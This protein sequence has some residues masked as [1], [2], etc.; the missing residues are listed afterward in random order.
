MKKEF[1]LSLSA[2][3]ALAVLTNSVEAKM[4]TQSNKLYNSAI[5]HEQEGNYLKALE[6]V[7]KSLQYSPDDAV[8]NIKLAGLYAN[9]GKYQEAI[10]A[11]NK[12]IL[13]RNDD[14]FLHI[15]L[16]NLYLQQYD[17]ALPKIEVLIG[18]AEKIPNSYSLQVQNIL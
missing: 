14:G 1:L 18:I 2:I 3:C 6:Y 5:V 9:L 10:E 17:E 7:Q 12:A 15:G 13:L 4:S 11:Y 16:A 8:L